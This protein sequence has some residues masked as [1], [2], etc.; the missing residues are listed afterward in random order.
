MA[1]KKGWLLI[2][3]GVL[4]LGLAYVEYTRW[5]YSKLAKALHDP[6]PVIRMD[7]L[8]KAGQAGQGDLL[9]EALH[10]EDPDIRY[11]AARSFG[12]LGSGDSEK[13][14]ALLELC[15][16]DHAYV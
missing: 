2:L 4:V 16:D 8:R 6:K 5:R 3:A 10:D 12:R 9:M 11:V 14:R 1:I 15:N 7:V 13:V